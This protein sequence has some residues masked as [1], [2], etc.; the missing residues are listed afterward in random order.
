MPF[1]IGRESEKE[2]EAEVEVEGEEQALLS[3]E[4]DAGE[5]Q[6]CLGIEADVSPGKVG[7]ATQPHQREGRLRSGLVE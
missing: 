3:A 4:L 6:A 2:D 7:H 1:A 5:V